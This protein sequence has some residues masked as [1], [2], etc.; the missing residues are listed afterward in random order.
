MIRRVVHLARLL[1][2]GRSLRHAPIALSAAEP[3]PVKVLLRRPGTVSDV[4]EGIAPLSLIPFEIGIYLARPAAEL[5]PA[6]ESGSLEFIDR[7]TG[8]PVGWLDVV[9]DGILGGA[10]GDM[11]RLRPSRPEVLCAPGLDRRWKYLL[12]WR[13]VRSNAG[14]PGHLEMTYPDLLALNV[15]YM[16]PRPVYL[17]SVMHEERSNLFPMDLVRPVGGDGFLLALRKSSPSIE[18]IRGSGRVV[19]SSVP[20]EQKEVAYRLGDQHRRDRVDWEALPFET[21]RSAG[22]SFPVPRFALRVRELEVLRSTELG[23]HVMFETRVAGDSGEAGGLQ[24]AH[25]SDMY[26]AAREREGRPFVE[27]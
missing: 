4:T 24:L 25:V 20:A 18:L 19:F 21:T 1:K 27:A 5:V 3:A 12:A 11:V 16:L 9:S 22:F 2:S 10:L 15:F 13:Q 17:V 7:K 8:R 14:R 23:S 26:R 6:G